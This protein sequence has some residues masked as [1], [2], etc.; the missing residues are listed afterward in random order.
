MKALLVALLLPVL[1]RAAAPLCDAAGARQA[2]LAADQAQ[3][4][5]L[6]GL[7][8]T[9]VEAG[10]IPRLVESVDQA[11]LRLEA[12]AQSAYDALAI[13]RPCAEAAT[14]A[15]K[16]ASGVPS[17]DRRVRDEKEEADNLEKKRREA[18]EF[19]K[20]VIKRLE[21]RL[22]SLPPDHRENVI[23]RIEEATEL[24]QKLSVLKTDAGLTEAAA[25]AEIAKSA[26]DKALDAHSQFAATAVPLTAAAGAVPPVANAAREAAARIGQAPEA[27]NRTRAYQRI[28]ELADLLRAGHQAVD[29]AGNR[30]SDYDG[31][32][33]TARKTLASFDDAVKAVRKAREE[34]A[35]FVSSAAVRL[36]RLS[37]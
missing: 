30:L 26:A 22:P 9:P 37:R 25:A 36:D 13:I 24:V 32:E 8:S 3:M 7:L 12:C 27:E 20:E 15:L 11:R 19:G 23:K 29:S 4:R 31:R 14:A 33:K 17:L 1:A 5:A 2:L 10:K 21:G 28:G 34:A 35:A 6:D 18:V 16:G